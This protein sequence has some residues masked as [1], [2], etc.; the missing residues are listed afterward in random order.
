[1]KHWSTI[2]IHYLPYLE[3]VIEYRGK[4]LTLPVSLVKWGYTYRLVIV[5]SDIEVYFEP[6][7]EGSYR[8]IVEDN[9]VTV[10][11][12]LLETIIKQLVAIRE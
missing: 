2:F 3:I 9:S 4:E 1:M 5:L 8:A 11:P 12:E 7:E 10:D 6:D